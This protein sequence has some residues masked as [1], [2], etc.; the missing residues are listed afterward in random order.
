MLKSKE[1]GIQAQKDKD[2]VDSQW[3][4]KPSL[5]KD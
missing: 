4:K 2:S 5:R 1:G 3:D